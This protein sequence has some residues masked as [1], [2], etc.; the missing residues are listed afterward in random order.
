MSRDNKRQSLKKWNHTSRQKDPQHECE[1]RIKQ[2]ENPRRKNWSAGP[3][4]LGASPLQV[5]R[6]AFAE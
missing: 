2:K 5:A 4:L 3:I 6:A 1:L